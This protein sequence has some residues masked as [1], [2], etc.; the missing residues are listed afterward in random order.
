MTK[1]T[2]ALALIND[3]ARTDAPTD[4]RATAAAARVA[5][6]RI[7][8][9]LAAASNAA[10]ASI[11]E[12]YGADVKRGALTIAQRVAWTLAGDAR[13]PQ[14]GEAR[15]SVLR[16]LTILE[17]QG[18]TGADIT[19]ATLIA[20]A[21][22]ATARESA[23]KRERTAQKRALADILKKSDILPEHV[24]AGANDT[25]AAMDAA[26]AVESIARA[27]RAFERA[28]ASALAALGPAVVV[29]MVDAA[30]R[31]LIT[32]QDDER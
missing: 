9:A 10:A 6:E 15:A 1:K 19:D 31:G 28:L 21:Q 18:I 26:D 23:R 24:V 13:A 4:G 27:S 5:A 30:V 20:A 14:Q 7:A 12:R 22:A 11:A 32:A 25:L 17:E 3:T 29:D 2:S 16:T 8:D